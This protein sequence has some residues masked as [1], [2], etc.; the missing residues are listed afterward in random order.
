MRDRLGFSRWVNQP[1][2]N[3]TQNIF[4]RFVKT[5]SGGLPDML[6]DSR[7]QFDDF[8]KRVLKPKMWEDELD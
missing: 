1:V 4:R 6:A 2:R 7:K 8:G 5:P 3:P